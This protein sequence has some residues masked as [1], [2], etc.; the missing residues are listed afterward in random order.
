M[1]KVFW[2][3]LAMGLV[4]QAFAGAPQGQPGRGPGQRGGG[5]GQRG[6]NFGPQMMGGVERVDVFDLARRYET[7]TPEQLAAIETLEAQRDAE[8]RA[9]LAELNKQLNKKFAALVAEALPA[10]E[11]EKYEKAAAALAEREEA[12]TAAE[13]DFRAAL[14]KLRAAQGVELSTAFGGG[15]FLPQGKG[16]IIRRYIKLTDAQHTAIDEV[17]RGGFGQMRDLMRDTPRP[18]DWRDAAA[19]RK[20]ADAA[21]KVRDQIDEQ[22]SKAMVDLLTDDQK[23]AYEPAA[24][25]SDTYKKAVKDAEAAY[26]KK[27]VD[28]YGEAKV[29]GAPAPAGANPAE[30]AKKAAEF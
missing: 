26:D 16:D 17:R 2:A 18:Q 5:P 12:L 25:A 19:R 22:T 29:H 20:Y 28:L 15:R 24:A 10:A 23:K 3:M 13:K 8:Q 30:P 14:E 6:G 4:A 1:R 7:L 27:L 21:A 9:A 11:K